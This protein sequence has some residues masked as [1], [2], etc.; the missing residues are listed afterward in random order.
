M[1]AMQPN[2][3]KDVN[4]VV[5]YPPD[6]PRHVI[7][8]VGRIRQILTNLTSNAIKF[9]DRGHVLINVE[10]DSISEDG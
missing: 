1:I 6:V 7:G 8:D 2:R 4:V 9:T 10:T 5:R 3:K